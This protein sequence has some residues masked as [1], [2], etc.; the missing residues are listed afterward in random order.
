MRAKKRIKKG[1][2]KIIYLNIN[3][4]KIYINIETNKDNKLMGNINNKS[5]KDINNK[6]NC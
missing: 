6:I 5:V 2:Q 3:N 4:K 1:L